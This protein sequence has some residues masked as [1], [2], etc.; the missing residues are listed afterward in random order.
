MESRKMNV[1]A[2]W[3]EMKESIR[4]A[5]GVFYQ[6][7]P[8]RR[9]VATMYD[10]ENIRHG[11]VY[12]QTPLNMNDPFDSMIG[13]SAE[14]FFNECIDQLM[15]VI[16]LDNPVQKALI[17]SLL[18]SKAIGKSAEV[19]VLLEKVRRHVQSRRKVM[20]KTNVAMKDFINQHY[21]L[22]Y[23]SL[24]KEEKKGMSCKEF[25]CYAHVVRK[26]GDA[27]IT[28]EAIIAMLGCDAVLEQLYAQAI[29]LRDTKYIPAMQKFLSQLTVTCFSASGWNNQL[30]WSHYA[31]SY[32]GICIEY[33]FS[34][35]RDFNGFIYPITYSEQRSTLTL[36]ELGLHF[37]N[38]NGK[39]E[40]D[41]QE[42]N[43]LAVIKHMLVKNRCWE[44]EN[45]WRII[46]IGEPDTPRFVDL[47]Y[48][49]SITFGLK[50]DPICRRLLW[51][52]CQEKSIQCYQIT[53][54]TDA[55]QLNRTLLTADDFVYD[56]ELETKYVETLVKHY[57]VAAE[58]IGKLATLIPG[59]GSDV[60]DFSVMPSVLAEALDMIADSHF[61]KLSLNRVCANTNEEQLRKDIS[62]DVLKNVEAI[63]SFVQNTSQS[64][65][66]IETALLG[67]VL[68]KK[69]TWK[70]HAIV[71]K[72]I[73][74]IREATGRFDEVAWNPNLLQSKDSYPS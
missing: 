60:K 64:I 15:D 57:Q 69:L 42:A 71:K 41:N 4:Q 14:H 25:L 50:M 21:S 58:R 70:E 6:Y 33:D 44:Y 45:E 51:E 73:A 8:C 34:Q 7:R 72:R 54:S 27:P 56:G 12:A 24:P 66:K 2:N 16:E 18:K 62:E 47:P 28:Q 29:N 30:M 53:V 65:T 1:S 55:F 40:T 22:L 46:N 3:E 5:G 26:M 52:V 38:R 20:H 11:V 48:V 49:K 39:I 17:K 13:F 31:N 43:I 9:D 32:A 35:I 74:D 63:N 19:L 10:I 61:L 59:E 23:E 37:T 67:L 68:N 36:S